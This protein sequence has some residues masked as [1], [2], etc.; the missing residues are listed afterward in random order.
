MTDIKRELG[1][2]A[3]QAGYLLSDKIAGLI[4]IRRAAEIKFEGLPPELVFMHT[5]FIV[6][7]EHEDPA[8][9]RGWLEAEIAH[10]LED[11]PPPMPCDG[12][13]MDDKS[14]RL[15]RRALKAARQSP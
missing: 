4:Q 10:R 11:R 6:V 8:A 7:Y 12:R 14:E 13:P 3:L 2:L 15:F 5:P 1:R 9:I